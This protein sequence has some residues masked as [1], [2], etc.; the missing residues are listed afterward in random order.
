M[1]KDQ[2]KGTLKETAGKLQQTGG[3]VVG[4]DEQK[5]K[6]LAKRAEGKLQKQAGNI[7]EHINDLGDGD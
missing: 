3:E 4:S 7:K 1:N 6:G 2:I 5:A